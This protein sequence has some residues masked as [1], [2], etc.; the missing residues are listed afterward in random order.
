MHNR[1]D[2]VPSNLSPNGLLFKCLQALHELHLPLGNALL[3]KRNHLLSRLRP[4]QASLESGEPVVSQ[5]HFLS[6]TPL[7]I[8]GRLELYQLKYSPTDSL[9]SCLLFLLCLRHGSCLSLHSNI[10]GTCCGLRLFM[11]FPLF[12][13]LLQPAKREVVYLLD[14]DVEHMGNPE[15]RLG[16]LLTVFGF[17]LL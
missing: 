17:M 8:E 11:F 4:A 5:G 12:H 13:E 10:G 15:E 7:A 2:K 16:G 1:F 14:L 6:D 3:H 9:L